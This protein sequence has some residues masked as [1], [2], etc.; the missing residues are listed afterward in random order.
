MAKARI[1]VDPQTGEEYVLKNYIK[2]G[3][4]ANSDIP[5][6]PDMLVVSGF[7]ATIVNEKGYVYVWDNRST[8]RT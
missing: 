5:T 7:H 3:R 1:L 6:D 8:N 4:A 2:I